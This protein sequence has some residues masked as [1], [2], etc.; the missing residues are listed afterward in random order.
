MFLLH[1]VVPFTTII[2]IYNKEFI[3]VQFENLFPEI[4][5][6]MLMW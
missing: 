2:S 6:I 3:F 1:A 5:Q 4:F